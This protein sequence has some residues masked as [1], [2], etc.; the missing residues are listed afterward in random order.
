MINQLNLYRMLS[1]ALFLLGWL[2]IISQ[3]NAIKQVFGLKMLL[4]S[5]TL[6]LVIAGQIQDNLY[7]SQAMVIS[8][9]VVEA[10]VI[11]LALAMIVSIFRK[12]PDG[13]IDELRKLRG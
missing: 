9:L 11:A 13:N 5:V 3:K 10:I 2:C 6:T 7:L 8:A 1:L 4:Q 12:V